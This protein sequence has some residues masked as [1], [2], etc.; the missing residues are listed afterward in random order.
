MVTRGRRI[1][2]SVASMAATAAVC[3]L[4]IC[5]RSELVD[6]SRHAGFAMNS[7]VGVSHFAGNFLGIFWWV[8][9][10][11]I[12]GWILSLPIVLLAK[13][14]SGLRFWM[15]WAAGTCIGP[16]VMY[17][18]SFYFVARYSPGQSA[19][20]WNSWFSLATGVAGMATLL[21]LWLLRREQRI[22]PG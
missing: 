13:Q 22:V 3:D 9:L 20:V 17:A 12:P 16:C 2:Y 21:Y 5:M 10:F 15:W 1:G 7:T 6:A 11:C 8:L 4:A 14:L 19:P 18:V